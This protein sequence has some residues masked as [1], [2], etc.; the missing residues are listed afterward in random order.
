MRIANNI[1]ALN[2]HRTLINSDTQMSK[3]M[4]RLSSG[5]RIN[6]AADDAAGL[7]ISEK[8]RAQ[9]RG[10]NQ[11][12]RNAQDG[13]SMIQTAEGGLNEMHSILQRMR[14][15]AVQAGN[16]T[17]TGADKGEIQKEV[18]QLVSEIDR[19]SNDTEFNTK[20]LLNGQAGVTASEANG[21]AGA[22]LTIN[23]VDHAG[24]GAIA[25]VNLEAAIT[26][27]NTGA[28][29]QTGVY[30]VVISKEAATAQLKSDAGVS[31][32]A[33]GTLGEDGTIVLNG[34]NVDL[35]SADS[36]ATIVSKINNYT[37]QT[38]VVAVA[39]GGSINLDS[40]AL[41]T[42]A[43]LTMSTTDADFLQR[44]G[45]GLASGTYVLT[46]AGSDA[47]GTINGQAAI[48]NGNTLTLSK[49]GNAADGLAVTFDGSKVVFSGG[50]AN[51]TFD[52]IVNADG[53]VTLQIGA[54]ANQNLS[55]A[56]NDMG[57][58]SLGID[59][60]DVTTDA[61]AALLAIDDAL[62]AVSSE[63]SKLGAYQ[64]RLEHTISNLG[65]SA[66][67]ITASESRIRDIDMAKEMSEFTKNQ[68]L[69]QAST[70]MLAQA[71]QKSQSV[72]KLLG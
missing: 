18:D 61:D 56:I 11:A 39:S 40:T 20:K 72:L 44:L 47:V 60:L 35:A 46:D 52:S 64:N 31:G 15:L 67:N 71:N 59:T 16:D 62:D 5:Y 45:F 37:A 14:E 53:Q 66:E 54:N 57:T 41:G 63:R 2:T 69:T 36:V 8:M 21:M 70:S 30:S 4:E 32:A 19:I 23:G 7:A 49:D 1:S 65:V 10:L 6:K 27:I 43:T 38:G 25:K 68:I 12:S 48:G 17:L 29:T 26:N 24:A 51:L 28:N 33:A 55:F 34:V 13:I 22:G 3:S 50:T 58:S 42:A 9:V